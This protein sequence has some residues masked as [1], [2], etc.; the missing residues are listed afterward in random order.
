[1]ALWSVAVFRAGVARSQDRDQ[2][3]VGVVQE[4]KHGM[5]SEPAL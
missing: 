4:G 3:L 1:M 2:C 5:E